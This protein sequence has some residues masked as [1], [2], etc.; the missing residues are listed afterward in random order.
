MLHIERRVQIVIELNLLAAWLSTLSRTQVCAIL[1]ASTHAG[2]SSPLRLPDGNPPPHKRTIAPRGAHA[3]T[4]PWRAHKTA[5]IKVRLVYVACPNLCDFIQSNACPRAHLY[6][7]ACVHVCAYGGTGWLAGW[8]QLQSR[9]SRHVTALCTLFI[10]SEAPRRTETHAR[11]SIRVRAWRQLTGRQ[12]T[13]HGHSS[14]KWQLKSC[15][16]FIGICLCCAFVCIINANC[17]R[18]IQVTMRNRDGCAQNLCLV[19]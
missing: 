17:V 11:T 8:A 2:T 9:D 18:D 10:F 14:W 7:F 3:S 15:A 1:G 16:Q 4:W 6:A 19:S 12:Q 13:P 5:P